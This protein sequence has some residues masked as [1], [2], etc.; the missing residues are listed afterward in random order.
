MRLKHFIVLVSLLAWMGDAAVA[1]APPKPR[2]ED[3]FWKRKTVTKIDLEEKVNKPMVTGFDDQLGMVKQVFASMKAGELTAYTSERGKLT[4]VKTFEE[5]VQDEDTKG[6]IFEQ[7]SLIQ[8]TE[9]RIFD[10]NH[11]KMFF[12]LQQIDFIY[13]FPDGSP[14]Q[15]EAS[16][17]W[18]DLVPV[19]EK[20]IWKNPFNDAEF[21]TIKEIFELRL[22]HGFIVEQSRVAPK[23]LIESEEIKQEQIE[24][25]HNLW[26]Y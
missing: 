18:E 17:K 11:A 20:A 15:V 26:T 23:D 16:Y 25:E 6:I 1:Q 22:F 3:E 19:F 24:F 9:D 7:I 10:K 4:T 14:E 13:T 21:R 8:L 12:D 2:K 5:I